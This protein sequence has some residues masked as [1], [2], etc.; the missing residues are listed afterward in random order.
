MAEAF[1]VDLFCEDAGHELFCR[2][3]LRRL[4]RREKLQLD[5][6][7]QSGRGGAGRALSELRAW[8]RAA[9]QLQRSVPD[10]LV[11]LI[12]TNCDRWNEAHAEV[13]RIVDRS[14]FPRHVA[15]C[16]DP[17]IERWCLADRRSFLQ[18]VG[19]EPVADPGKCKRDLYKKLLRQS[20]EQAGQIVLGDAME[21]APDLVEAMD[22]YRAGR[23]QHS[24]K[25]FVDGLTA[26]LKEA[27]R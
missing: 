13:D 27:A 2:A 1:R 20:I 14:V 17:H 19:G 12:D 24:L 10:L 3:L 8:Q 15:G 6:A 5:L 18:V 25:H 21:F 11:V 4:A 9:G 22:L 7:V 16:P 26:A 23:A